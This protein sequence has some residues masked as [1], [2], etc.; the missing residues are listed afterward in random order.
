M[1][2]MWVLALGVLAFTGCVVEVVDEGRGQLSFGWAIEDAV[3]G[4]PLNCAPGETVQLSI[5][6]ETFVFD[7]AA[8]AAVTPALLVGDYLATF[9]LV[10]AGGFIESTLTM[11]V[12]VF[13]GTVVEV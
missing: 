7:C 13:G 6:G 12:S 5:G 11:R 9:D 3:T 1:R 8:H 4:A 2:K 10:A